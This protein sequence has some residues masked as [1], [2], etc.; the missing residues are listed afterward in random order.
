MYNSFK[1]FFLGAVGS[2]SFRTSQVPQLSYPSQT[3][4]SLFDDG[5]LENFVGKKY[6]AGQYFYG[7]RST[8]EQRKLQQ[9]ALLKPNAILVVGAPTNEVCQSVLIELL[10]KGFAVRYACDDATQAFQE[11]GSSGFNFDIV[12]LHAGSLLSPAST[13]R[14]FAAAVQDVQAIVLCQ[15]NEDKV[16]FWDKGKYSL[17]SQKLLNVLLRALRA[18]VLGLKKVVVTSDRSTAAASPVQ[19]AVRLV[20]N[21]CQICNNNRY[22]IMRILMCSLL[23]T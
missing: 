8:N 15:L 22:L 4:L 19:L 14:D 1:F 7:E 12:E 17:L 9:Q 5:V 13:E 23:A 3:R 10:E 16:K 20:N 11:L 2:W 18:G 21:N 6:G